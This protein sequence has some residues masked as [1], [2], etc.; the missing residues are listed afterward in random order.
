MAH[1]HLPDLAAYALAAA[2][3]ATT[4]V[5]P[6]YSALG[7]AAIGGVIGGFLSVS[8]VPEA[9]SESRRTLSVKWAVS[10]LTSIAITPFLFQRWTRVSVDPACAALKAMAEC[11]PVPA[12]LSNTAEA[13]LA[14]STTVAFLAWITL[15]LLQLAWEKRLRKAVLG[16]DPPAPQRRAADKAQGGRS[17]LRF[18]LWLLG[19]SLLAVAAYVGWFIL[20]FARAGH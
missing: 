1:Q 20:Q 10:T 4:L 5:P 18:I 19:L 9:N 8:I 7:V 3:A 15:R 12:L 16:S 2:G 17:I 13:M 6:D 14:L 11:A